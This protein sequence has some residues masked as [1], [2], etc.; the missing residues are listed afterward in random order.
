MISLPLK[1]GI[2]SVITPGNHVS[3]SVDR[4]DIGGRTKSYKQTIS[5]YSPN[6]GLRW[7]HPAGGHYMSPGGIK[8]TV[9]SRS[10]QGSHVLSLQRLLF[11]PFSSVC[12]IYILPLVYRS[13]SSKCRCAVLQDRIVAKTKIT[14]ANNISKH[15][16]GRRSRVFRKVN[17][18]I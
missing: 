4:Y 5:S 11:A 10:C 12:L 2:D 16:K 1:M 3:V 15:C 7:D 9:L 14:S 18:G 13:S 8:N 17:P 6:A